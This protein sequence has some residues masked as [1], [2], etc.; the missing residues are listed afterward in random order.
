MFTVEGRNEVLDA[1]TARSDSDGLSMFVRAYFVVSVSVGGILGLSRT[2]TVFVAEMT[3]DNTQ[4]LESKVDQL[5]AEIN[6]LRR[7]LLARSELREFP[8]SAG[9]KKS[10]DKSVMG[11]NKISVTEFVFSPVRS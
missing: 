8:N 7:G 5:H 6:P 2:S 11:R 9:E 3:M 4:N 1:I 10:E